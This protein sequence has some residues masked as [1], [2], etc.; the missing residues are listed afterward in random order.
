MKTAVRKWGNS[1]A[2][3]IPTV[4]MQAAHLSLDQE[5]DIREVGG[6]VIIEPV[7]QGS[8]NLAV[9]LGGIIDDNLYGAI[10]TGDIVGREV[11]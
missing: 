9:L 3:R 2:V 4:V 5:V 11:W 10:P 8:H 6:S 7:Q 1:A